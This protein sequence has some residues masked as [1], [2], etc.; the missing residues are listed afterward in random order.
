MKVD[1][2]EQ[3]QTL[4]NCIQSAQIGGMYAE[5]S[6]IVIQLAELLEVVKSAKVETTEQ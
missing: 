6:Q 4:I 2:E 3:R 1:N 5:V